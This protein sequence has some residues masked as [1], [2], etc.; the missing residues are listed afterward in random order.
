[1]MIEQNG[2][3][4]TGKQMQGRQTNR[5]CNTLQGAQRFALWQELVKAQG[6]LEAMRAT[7]IEAATMMTQRLGFNITKANVMDAVDQG[8]VKWK[9]PGR[10]GDFQ[11]K[12]LD[13]RITELENR[14]ASLEDMVLRLCEASGTG[15]AVDPMRAPEAW[16]SK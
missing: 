15:K 12:A 3:P 5:K 14:V 11:G 7:Y 8:I 1:M 2:R 6:E 10:G 4:T 13:G 9:T 16:V